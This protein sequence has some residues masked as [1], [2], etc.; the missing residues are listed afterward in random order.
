MTHM[1]RTVDVDVAGGTALIEAGVVLSAV[2]NAAGEHGL[3]TGI[4][5]AARDSSTVGRSRT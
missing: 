5:L 1:N 3:S 4:D 2:Q